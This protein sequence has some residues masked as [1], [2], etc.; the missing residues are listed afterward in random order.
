MTKQRLFFQRYGALRVN[1][2]GGPTTRIPPNSNALKQSY[3]V[4]HRA[5]FCPEPS[6]RSK[7]EAFNRLPGPP[8]P[9]PGPFPVAV[10]FSRQRYS[11]GVV[12][13]NVNHIIRRCNLAW[14]SQSILCALSRLF[15]VDQ[16][17][18]AR[19]G[20][21]DGVCWQ[22]DRRFYRATVD[23]DVGSALLKR[24]AVFTVATHTWRTGRPLACLLACLHGMTGLYHAS[25][26]EARC[27][28]S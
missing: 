10:Y 23:W 11:V 13:R 14:R 19:K 2:N 18:R 24:R 22:A 17:Q 3:Q 6:N 15:A 27:W 4:N 12:R 5:D 21:D 26:Y 16:R 1:H 7:R 8:P 20:Q 28:H 25:S 9:T